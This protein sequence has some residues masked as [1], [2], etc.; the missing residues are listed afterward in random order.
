MTQTN[1]NQLLKQVSRSFYLSMRVL[2]KGMRQPVAMAYLLARAAD[3]MTDSD[4]I[5]N[6]TRLSY[7]D[8]LLNDLVD[9]NAPNAVSI[10]LSLTVHISDKGEKKL[11]QNLPN[12]IHQF[13]ALE[14]EDKNQIKNVVTTL[15][16]GMQMD[17][18]TFENTTTIT[19][20]KNQQTLEKYIYLVA[21][22]VGEFWT[23]SAVKHLPQVAQWD[24]ANQ[25]QLG[26]EFGKALQLTNILRDIA[27]DA[28][29]N[30]CYLPEKDLQRNS[31]TTEMLLNKKN[32][33]AFRPLIF[34]QLNLAL[35][36]F[37]S[38][39]KYLFNTPRTTIRLRLGSIW[40]ILIGLKTLELIASKENFLDPEKNIKVQR[41]WVYSM[42]I[43]S[44]FIVQSNTLLKLWIN[45][46]KQ[47]IKHL[48][49]QKK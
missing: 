37:E 40:P 18:T 44:L 5:D 42:L 12:I 38:A 35:T 15:I 9:K 24:S 34:K 46:I 43:R 19:A 2:P 3:S 32:D 28:R 36:Y 29:L 47:N 33:V 4:E 20:L 6:K 26:I 23:I 13:H 30:R 7:L 41:K 45:Q 39:E 17:L 27:K 8:N 25:T 21:G 16:T 31:L 22:C 11:I 49:Q 1:F 14:D 48:L 10:A